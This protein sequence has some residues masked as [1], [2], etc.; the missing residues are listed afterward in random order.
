MSKTNR[1]ILILLGSIGLAGC[2]MGG[3]SI[4]TNPAQLTPET[5]EQARA[6]RSQDDQINEQ[7]GGSFGARPGK[8]RPY[9]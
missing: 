9:R 1:T 6:S 7:E 5:E 8:G 3:P 2:G 4:I